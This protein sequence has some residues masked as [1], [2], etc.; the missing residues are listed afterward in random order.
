MEHEY[1]PEALKAFIVMASLLA[2]VF[3]TRFFVVYI[4]P[5]LVRRIREGRRCGS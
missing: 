1:N 2:S 4:V 3:V 5:G